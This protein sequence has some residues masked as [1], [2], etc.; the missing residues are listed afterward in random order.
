MKKTVMGVMMT[1]AIIALGTM[2]NVDAKAAESYAAGQYTECRCFTD[3]NGD[4]ICD[5]SSCIGDYVDQDEDG[6]CDNYE[7]NDRSHGRCGRGT[8]VSSRGYR[9]G[10]GRRGNG[11][12]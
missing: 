10:C 6:I 2:Q 7:A 12:P 8:C 5:V 9:R 1:I 11:T 4:G 3:E